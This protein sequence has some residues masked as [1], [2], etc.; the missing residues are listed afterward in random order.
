VYDYFETIGKEIRYVWKREWS[1]GKA[2]FLAIRYLPFIDLSFYVYL[3]LTT[4]QSGLSCSL[5]LYWF[6]PSIFLAFLLADAVVALRT[7]AI[8]ERNKVLCVVLI[9]AWIVVLVVTSIDQAQ[10]FTS[11]T[12]APPFPGI[13][14]CVWI[15]TY[16][17]ELQRSY[18]TYAGYQTLVFIAT[19]VRGIDHWRA[20]PAKLLTILYKDAFLASFF[21]FSLAIVNIVLLQTS[22]ILSYGLSAVYRAMSAILPARIILNLREAA[23]NLNGWDVTTRQ[24]S[25]TPGRSVTTAPEE[26]ELE[27]R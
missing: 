16:P 1:F 5:A 7:W 20:S 24:L 18:I 26:V 25:T 17:Q 15:S 3:E 11:N 9:V 12:Y 10:G 23:L 21:L 4:V 19:I 14:G 2:L 6:I 8:W 22:P 13:A 27:E